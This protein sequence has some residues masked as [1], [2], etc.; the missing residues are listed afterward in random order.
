M[1]QAIIW[2]NVEP[3]GQWIYAELGGDELNSKQTPHTL[4]SQA[5][6]GVSI[7]RIFQKIDSI[8]T[9]PYRI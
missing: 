7:M 5:S 8:A 2:T 9:A 1:R 3:V 4:P 6:Y